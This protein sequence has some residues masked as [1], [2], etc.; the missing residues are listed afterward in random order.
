[1]I[2]AH[3]LLHFLAENPQ[4]EVSHDS[5]DTEQWMVHAVHGG[6]NDRE[7]TT[8]GKGDTPFD[9]LLDAYRNL[10]P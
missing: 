8:V 10:K 5:Y 4:L 7:W 9:A 6:R 1:M 3:T 2:D